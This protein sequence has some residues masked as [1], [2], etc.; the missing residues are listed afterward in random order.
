MEELL[1]YRCKLNLIASNELI[2]LTR[3][4]ASRLQPKIGNCRRFDAHVRW[5]KE[6]ELKNEQL[7][8]RRKLDDNFLS[9]K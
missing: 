3:A 1:I 2:F 7:K 4:L 5:K 6:N 9:T 8:K